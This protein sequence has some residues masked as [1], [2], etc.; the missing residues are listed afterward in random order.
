MLKCKKL[1]SGK[2]TT[3]T[4]KNGPSSTATL[5]RVQIK[6]STKNLVSTSIE[7]L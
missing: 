1:F 6:D 5:S 3:E 4:T 7:S 2:S